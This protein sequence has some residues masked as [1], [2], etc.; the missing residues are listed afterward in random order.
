MNEILVNGKVPIPD[1]IGD[2]KDSSPFSI[3]DEIVMILFEAK[4]IQARIFITRE[5]IKVDVWGATRD[6]GYTFM[7]WAQEK[8]Q[9]GLFRGG[10]DWTLFNGPL[11]DRNGYKFSYN[12]DV[13]V[14]I[15][16]EI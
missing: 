16:R 14:D 4:A 11:F 9:K 13:H 6:G 12:F 8:T 7:K 1:T 2:A 5:R 15:P 3:Q 10:I